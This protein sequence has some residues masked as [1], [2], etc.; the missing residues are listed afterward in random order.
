MHR[1][2]LPL[3]RQRLQSRY[4]LSYSTLLQAWRETKVWHDR[5]VVN[6]FAAPGFIVCASL[7]RF[8]RVNLLREGIGSAGFIMLP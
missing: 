3:R 2:R 1:R 7:L 4:P 5:I 6:C 8:V